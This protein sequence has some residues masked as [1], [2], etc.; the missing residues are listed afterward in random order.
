M[1]DCCIDRSPRWCSAKA[2]VA[3]SAQCARPA[4]KPQILAACCCVMTVTSATTLTAW[5]PHCRMFPKT[6]GSAN[7]ERSLSHFNLNLLGMIWKELEHWGGGE[8]NFKS[9]AIKLIVFPNQ[10]QWKENLNLFSFALKSSFFRLDT[11]GKGKVVFRLTSV[12]SLSCRCVSCT[13]CGATTPG[14][15]CEWQNNYTQCA[16]CASLCTCPICLVDYSEG[17]TI[18]QCRQCDRQVRFPQSVSAQ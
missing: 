13:Q 12:S 3:W 7:G 16:P 17:T 1:S 5:I 4:A 6:A 14:L 2:G 11:V 15:R 8:I 10:K 9:D 18:L